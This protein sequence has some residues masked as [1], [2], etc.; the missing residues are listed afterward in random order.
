[1]TTSSQ[2]FAQMKGVFVNL[3]AYYRAL[4]DHLSAGTMLP[5]TLV[6]T[7]TDQDTSDASSLAISASNQGG[8]LR[9]G[10]LT[11]AVHLQA[12]ADR[13]V[14]MATLNKVQ[15]YAAA[16]AEA[17]DDAERN[18]AT[19]VKYESKGRAGR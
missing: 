3:E 2:A 4:G 9:V 17:S 13:E 5:T 1:V 14:G 19:G 18:A 12:A 6:S 15:I 11:D 8:S 16:A 7:I 10:V